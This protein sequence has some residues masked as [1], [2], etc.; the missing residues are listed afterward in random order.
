ML[1]SSIVFLFYFFPAVLLIYYILRFSNTL[2][3]IFLL[4][5]S[6]F[7]YAWGEPWF[8][9]IM[10]VSIICN[11][12]FALL[13]DRYRHKKS[14]SKII[15]VLMCFVNLG[16]LFFFKYLGFAVRTITQITNF[17]IHI[18]NIA[19][20]IGISFFTFQA[21]SYVVDV[22]R[23]N[24]NVQKNPFYVALYISFFP[25]LIA[26]PI[27]RY[28]TIA[29]QIINRKET[30]QKFSIGTCRFITGLS[31]KVLIANNMAVV[32]DRIFEMNIV[33]GV[34]SSLAWLGSVAYTLQIFFDFSGY[35]DM[36]IGIGLMFGFK[37]E[38]NFNYPYISK[39]I[40]EFWRRWHM[41]LGSWFKEYVYFPLGGS[42]I[43]NKDKVIRNL[44]IV[45]LLTGIWHGAEWTFVLWGLWNFTFI[46]VEKFFAIDKRV[47]NKITRNLYVLFVVNL[48]WVI[49]RADNLVEAGR[50]VSSMFKFYKN[51]F[52]SDYTAMFLKEYI[53]FFTAGIVFSTP[54][55]KRMN[56]FI[57]DGE[58]GS[59]ILDFGYTFVIISLFLI[60]VSYLTKGTY[61][62]FIY[63]NF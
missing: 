24:G 52:W 45:W 58:P 56:K 7:F 14:I 46:A 63:F 61:N 6:L 26:G 51:G 35:S 28:S 13:V 2:K 62:P 57:V 20:P 30:W 18:P 31:K 47:S 48:G 44:F 27:V 42:R 29:N 16:L 17:K 36:A 4:F 3:N 25:Q 43:K 59:K 53:V 9:L 23:K 11:Y 60:C 37:F 1:F 49:F 19:L 38:E 40:T 8:V 39:S 55:A 5:A 21:M 10:I 34:P 50:F 15:L 12:V 33:A 41:S 54:I 32:A 22:Y